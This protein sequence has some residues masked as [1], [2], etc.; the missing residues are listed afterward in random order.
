MAMPEAAPAEAEAQAPGGASQLVAD[1]HSNLLKL[2]DM[3][4]AKFPEDA[5]ELGA[6]IQ[7]Y[8]GFVENLS[9]AP[10]QKQGPPQPGTTTPEAG[11]ADV[12]PA[13]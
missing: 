4:Q 10:G 11:A 2:A 1:I 12:Q 13:M 9:Q 8:Q 3:I 6:I 7:A 5:Q